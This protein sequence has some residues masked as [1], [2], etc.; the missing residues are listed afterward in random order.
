MEDLFYKLASGMAAKVMYP[1]FVLFGFILF[2]LA[3]VK[4][5]SWKRDLLLRQEEDEAR[6]ELAKLK[7]EIEQLK[8]AGISKTQN[9][10]DQ[11]ESA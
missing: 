4:L 9:I 1:L 8:Q 3:V 10:G 2:C 7:V 6:E 5:V 11:G